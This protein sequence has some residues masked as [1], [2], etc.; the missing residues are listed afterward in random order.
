MQVRT[1]NIGLR[2]FLFKR[3][4]PGV[5][6]PSYECGEGPETVEHLVIWCVAPLLS[7]SWGRTEIQTRRD[8]YSV[9]QGIDPPAAGLTRRILSWLMDVGALPMYNLARK[10]ELE[11]AV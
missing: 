10:L 7:R 3:G 5:P 9:L 11:P 8:L 4:V 2:D 6:T 1:S